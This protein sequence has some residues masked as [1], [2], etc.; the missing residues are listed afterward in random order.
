MSH[1]KTADEIS[2]SYLVNEQTLLAYSRRGNLPQRRT[3][4]GDTLFSEVGVARLFRPRTANSNDAPASVRA[5]GAHVLGSTLLGA[6]P[7]IPEA[8]DSDPPSQRRLTAAHVRGAH[9]GPGGAHKEVG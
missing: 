5:P 4:E 1:W 7:S 3:P 9:S 8:R 2:K 6:M